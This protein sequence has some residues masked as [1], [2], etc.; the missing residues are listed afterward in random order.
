MFPVLLTIGNFPI[1]SFGLLLALGIFLGAFTVW[2][3]ARSF[4]FESEKILD[5]IFL[6]LGSGLLFSR[7][8]FV[9]VNLPVFDSLSKIFFINRYP[10]LS[11]WGG[12][13]GGFIAL[14]WL[15]RRSKIR[16]LQLGDMAV[17]GM[18]AASFWAEIGCL[19]GACGIG[20][21]TTSILSVDQVGAIGKRF[22]VQLFEA[23]AFLIIF[24]IFWKRIL[25][26]HVQGT[27]L[28]GG[29]MLLAIIKFIAG[30]F[31][32]SAQVISISGYP[33]R[34][35]LVLSVLVFILGA[36][37]H[38]SINKKTPLTDIVMILKFFVTPSKQKALMTKIIRWCYNLKINFRVRLGRW[39]KRLFKNINVRS[40]PD[41]FKQNLP[42]S[43]VKQ[44][45]LK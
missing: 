17:V 32:D 25:R 4:D 12:F 35:D 39:F 24:L 29:L 42:H 10:G 31:K 9:L 3:I 18:F 36:Y 5:L 30:F 15:S 6:T 21:P 13:L 44:K 1:S 37:Y 16:F 38:Y 43:E 23:I 34:I 28:A 14:L 45:D 27:F 19:M 20:I 11:F 7:L 2:R 41:T 26:F 22:P 33:I 40:N 8:L